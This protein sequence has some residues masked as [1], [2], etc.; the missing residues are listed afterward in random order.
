MTISTGAYRRFWHEVGERFPDL[1]GAVSTQ[2]YADNEQR[3]F[4]EHLPRLD[5]LRVLKTDLWDEAR[6]T[7]ILAWVRQQ[8]AETYGIDISMPTLRQAREPFGPP[9]GDV[10]PL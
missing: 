3:L 7:R 8:G 6:N 10:Q 4:R 5:G 9:R 1:A 2:Y